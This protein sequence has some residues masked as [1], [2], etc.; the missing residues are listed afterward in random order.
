MVLFE[1]L[2]DEVVLLAF[3]AGPHSGVEDLFLDGGVLGQRFDH[4]ADGRLARLVGGI[5]ETFE[6][7][8]QLLD[9]AV[10]GLQ[11]GDGVLGLRGGPARSLGGGGRCSG[12]RL[13]SP[14]SEVDQTCMTDGGGG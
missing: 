14:R 7:L 9:V 2:E 10:L 11:E 1:R 5:A 3:A 13:V 6:P 8:E 4:L 12:H